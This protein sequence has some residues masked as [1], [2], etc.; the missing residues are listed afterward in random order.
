MLSLDDI[1]E[2]LRTPLIGVIPESDKV[3]D[4]VE[5]GPALPCT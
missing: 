4:A 2:I 1:Q 3:L 5:P